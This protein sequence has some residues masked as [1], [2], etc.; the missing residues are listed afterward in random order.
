MPFP[1]DGRNHKKAV[2]SEKNLSLYKEQIEAQYSKKIVDIIA[3]GGTTTKVDNTII[4]ED[5]TSIDA[6]LKNKKNARSGSF[7]YVNT[8]NFDWCNNGFSDTIEIYNNF[9]NSGD[10]KAYQLLTKSISKNLQEMSNESITKLFIENVIDKYKNI[11]LFIINEINNKIFCNVIPVAFNLISEGGLLSLKK[12]TGVKMSYKLIGIDKEGKEI[13][14]NLRI[15]VH[16][17]NGKTKWL[18]KGSSV[19]VIKFQ[20]DSVYKML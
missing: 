16:L 6:S 17:N 10:F 11:E 3:K 18:S 20:Q 5:G 15:R 9:S 19:L 4:F 7:D 13:D 1:S 14:L 8:S 2:N 12:T